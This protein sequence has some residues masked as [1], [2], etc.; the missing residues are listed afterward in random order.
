MIR[1]TLCIDDAVGEHRRALLDPFGKPFRLEVERWSER[2]RRAKLDEIWWGRVKARMPGNRGWF[3]DLGLDRD[4]IIE[5]SKAQAIAEGAML[6]VRVKSEAWAE[7]GLVLS[8]ADM[9][10]SVPRPD[11]PQLHQPP[12]DDLFL[13]GVVVVA[14][15]REEA[16]RA[17]V[18]GAI[19]ES[20]QQ[21]VG[22]EGGGDLAIQASRAMTVIDVDAA[23]R[24]GAQDADAFALDLNLAAAEEAARQ[25][26]LRG[27][28]G[29]LAVD[30]VGMK[31]SKHQRAVAEAF[32]K[33]LAGWLGRA[34]E[35]LELSQLGVCEA[36][37]ARRARPVRDALSA[38]A[39][40]REALDALREI[41]SAGWTARGSK[42]RARVSQEAAGW[43]ETDHIGW[44]QALADRIG[45][46]WTLEPQDRPP[47]RAEVWSTE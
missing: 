21:V 43:L 15:L 6:A 31:Q 16:G 24:V 13:R 42:I 2:G 11:K 45:A 41:E 36:A 3:V 28:G 14:T 35:V 4:G 12:A 18:E 40:E 33:A 38:P 39:H 8:L 26:S 29:L 10:P 46:R 34:S 47:G 22:L 37:I 7:K 30:F 32:R 27:I 44:G 9:S 20:G 5:Q 19:V 1:A 25:I 17:Q 23:E